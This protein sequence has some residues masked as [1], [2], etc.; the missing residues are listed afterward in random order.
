VQQLLIE[1]VLLATVGTLAA[2]L[3]LRWTAGLLMAFVPPSDLPIHLD[4]HVDSRV[5]LFTAA[6]A[7]CT[8]LLFALV[9]ALQATTS[10][11]VSGLRDGGSTG[12]AFGRHRL[13][14]ALV[15]AQVALSITLLVG[16]GLCVRSL[17]VAR[18]ATPGFTADGVVL[19]WLDLFAAS[20]GSDSGQDFYQRLLDRVRAMPGVESATLGR[21]VP[22][23]FGGGSS[24]T[25]T[26]DGYQAPDDAPAFAQFNHVGPDYFR[27][28]RIPIISGRD[29]SAADVSGRRRVAVINETMAR[30]FWKGRDPIN[31][32]FSFS[33]SPREEDYITVVGVIGDI[34]YRSMTE[35]P[36]AFFFLPVLQN[37]QPAMVLHVRAAGDPTAV[38]ADL[39][40]VVR[41]MDPNVTFYNVGLMSA[42]TGAAT[43]TQRLAA[44]LLV[45][46]G[47]LALLLAAIGS[48]GVLSYLVGQRRREIGIRLAIGA[49]RSSVFRLIVSSGARLVAIGAVAGFVMAVGLGFALRGL[50]IGIKPT[51]PVTYVS[52][53]GILVAVAIAA[54]VLPARRAA[55]LNPV[56]T[57]RED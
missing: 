35:A 51:D 18:I 52:V 3:A 40:R 8:V 25:L 30:T 53:F 39:P 38:T 48:Y 13:R 12:R 22:L 16:A 28:L 1:G 36:Q 11:L 31:G 54:C 10:N 33:R 20:Y 4:V 19:G 55:S 45:V 41:E 50:L 14:R 46:F 21:R 2:L 15:A 29:L 26:V 56:T 49:T 43:F 24:S 57:L 7:L 27:T 37:F 47:G 44:N 9:P 5:V 34:K 32:R 6:I 17:A 42:H 23:S